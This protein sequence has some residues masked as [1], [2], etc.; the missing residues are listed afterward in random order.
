MGV[1]NNYTTGNWNVSSGFEQTGD[2]SYPNAL[3]ALGEI[4]NSGTRVLLQYGDSDYVCNWL[5]GEAVS[6]ELNYTHSD[7]FRAAG[8]APIVFGGH[9]YG[10]VREYGNF[11]FTRLYEAGHMTPYYQPLATLEIFRRALANLDVAEGRTVITDTYA[12]NGTEKSTH[13]EVS[14][15]P[16]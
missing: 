6:L 3:E 11:S 2:M 5:G 13:T 7:H 4:L 10:A 16:L 14:P 9:E 12:T 15:P 8:Y 1:S